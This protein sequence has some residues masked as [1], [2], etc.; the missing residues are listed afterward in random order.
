MD[1][2]RNAGRVVGVLLLLQIVAGGYVNFGLLERVFAAPGYLVNAAANSLEMGLAAVLGLALGLV[3]VGIGVTAFPVFRRHSETMALFYFALSVASLVLIAV[4]Y[5]TVLSLLSLSQ[6]NAQANGADAN[7]WQAL[8]G[9]VG[10]ARNWAHFVEILVGGVAVFV[11]YVTLY[12]FAFVPR[13][14]AGIGMLAALLQMGSVGRALFGMDVM[15]ELLLPL[16]LTQ[17][18][19]SLWLIFRGFVAEPR[20]APV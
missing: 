9:V 19:L 18:A 7:L 11:L 13:A 5:T 1:A 16:G 20:P 15:F 17:L 12:R 8:R 10:S 4:E 6:A 2:T 3:S 14:L